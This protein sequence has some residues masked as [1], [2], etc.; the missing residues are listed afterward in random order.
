MWEGQVARLWWSG[1]GGG[2]GGSSGRRTQELRG[3]ALQRANLHLRMPEASQNSSRTYCTAG[4]GR[5]ERGSSG[6]VRCEA[7]EFVDL[8][9]PDSGL[10]GKLAAKQSRTSA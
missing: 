8:K 3:G 6:E 7:C 10:S 2:G 1:S 4:R 5:A 9:R